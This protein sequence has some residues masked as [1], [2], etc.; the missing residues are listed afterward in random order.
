MYY[1]LIKGPKVTHQFLL[2]KNIIRKYISHRSKV[3]GQSLGVQNVLQFETSPPRYILRL[4]D[5]AVS[6]VVTNLLVGFELTFVMTKMFLLDYFT[7]TILTSS[8]GA[9]INSAVFTT[10]RITSKNLKSHPSI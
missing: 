7:N 9:A 6:I 3:K 4:V 8:Q 10:A 1:V 2:W 5:T